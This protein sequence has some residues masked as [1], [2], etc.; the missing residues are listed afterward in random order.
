MANEW[1]VLHKRSELAAEEAQTISQRQ[2]HGEIKYT[3][4]ERERRRKMKSCWR[5]LELEHCS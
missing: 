5:R 4:R 3:V 1:K 2:Q